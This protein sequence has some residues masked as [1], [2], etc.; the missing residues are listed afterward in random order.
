[1]KKPKLFYVVSYRGI[2]GGKD[3]EL[4]TME[5][6]DNYDEAINYFNFTDECVGYDLSICEVENYFREKDGNWNYED[7]SNTF[8][9]IITLINNEA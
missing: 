2:V 3:E 6:F 1:M 8:R 7:Y 9:H 5:I 4:D